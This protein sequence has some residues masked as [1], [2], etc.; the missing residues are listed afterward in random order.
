MFVV[1][2]GAEEAREWQMAAIKMIDKPSGRI[3]RFPTP[4]PN[5]Y[6]LLPGD[7][8]SRDRDPCELARRRLQA[9]RDAVMQAAA[10]YPDDRSTILRKGGASL[11]PQIEIHNRLCPPKYRVEPIPI[12]VPRLVQ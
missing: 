7:D 10:N 1:L 9:N 8:D 12:N 3:Y 6:N 11:N 4:Q 5:R 2:A